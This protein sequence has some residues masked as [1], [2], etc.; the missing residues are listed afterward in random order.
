MNKQLNKHK[1]NT[2]NAQNKQNVTTKQ[3]NS[4][5]SKAQSGQG[6]V[7]QAPRST[8]AARRAA[9]QAVKE[10]QRRQEQRVAARTRG[11]TIFS[12]IGAIIVV[13]AVIV[14]VTF[15]NKGQAAPVNAA[16]PAVDGISCDQLEQTQVH[17]HAY[18]AMYINGSASQLPALVGI[19]SDQ[20]CYYWLHTH[21]TSGVI[22]IESPANKTFTFGNFLDEW[23]QHFSSLGYPPELDFSSGWKIWING[24]PYSG[25]YRNIVLK[26]HEIITMAYDS[27]GVKPVTTYNWNGL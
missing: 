20:S 18:L 2:S 5:G 22:H 24:Q 3:A 26:S 19:A 12:I 27:P 1:Q 11:I 6:L 7:K 17:Y 10:Q 4:N 23:S 13:V 25:S 14:G 15:L 21:D 9:Q 8:Q 16:Y